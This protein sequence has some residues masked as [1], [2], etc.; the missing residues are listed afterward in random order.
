M[1][2]CGVVAGLST[3]TLSGTLGAVVANRWFVARRGL[4]TGL[5]GGGASVGQLIFIPLL[6]NLTVTIDWRAALLLMVGLL[7][8]LLPIA[9]FV[10]RDRPASVGLEPYGAAPASVAPL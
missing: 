8:I 9:L 4:V 10:I 2:W 5:L 3:G 1:W 7:G 6:M